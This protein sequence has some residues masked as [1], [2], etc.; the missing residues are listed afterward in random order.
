[1]EVSDRLVWRVL[2]IMVF[3]L[4]PAPKQTDNAPSF[5]APPDGVPQLSGLQHPAAP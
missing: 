5:S 2:A 3:S 1:M 4:D